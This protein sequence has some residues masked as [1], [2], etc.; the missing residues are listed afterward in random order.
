ME[1]VIHWELCN[2]FKFDHANKWYMHN[3]ESVL[4]NQKQKNSLKFWETNRSSN[5]SQMTG[6]SDYQKKKKKK[7]KKRELVEL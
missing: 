1:K 5:F 6:T 2:K 4:E 3:A 7:R